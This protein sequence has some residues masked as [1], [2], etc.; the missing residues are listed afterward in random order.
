MDN[1]G[2][3]PSDESSFREAVRRQHTRVDPCFMT[4]KGCVYRDT[5]DRTLRDRARTD[6]CAGFMIMP[7]RDNLDVFYKNTLIPFFKGNYAADSRA[8]TISLERADEVRRPGIIICEGICK[9]VQES[10]FVVVDISVPNDNV[11][12]E[13]GLAYGIGQKILVVHHHAAEFGK[14]MA[15]RFKAAGYLSFAYHD[16]LPI[17]SVDFSASRH[18]WPSRT[19]TGAS[20]YSAAEPD[21]LFLFYEHLFGTDP[22]EATF[23]KEARD[24]PKGG[25]IALSFR[26]HVMSNVGLAVDRIYQAIPPADQA[27]AGGRESV[28]G[29]YRDI[30]AKLKEP[31]FLKPESQFLELKAQ[32]DSCYCMM[33]RTGREVHPLSYFWLGYGH[34]LGKNIIPITVAV[35]DEKKDNIDDLA[36]DIRAQ[37]HMTFVL[38]KPH[39]LETQIRTTLQEMIHADF[40]EW[41]RKRFWDQMLGKR[42]EVSV[43]T[44]A[45]HHERINREMIGDWDLRAA[46]ELMS[47]F[48]RH[49]YRAK[50]ETPIYSLEYAKQADTTI[51]TETYI[52]QLRT[53]ME[54]KNCIL[55]ASPDVNPL[56]EIVLGHIYG[57]QSKDLFR[58]PLNLVEHPHAMV[59]IKQVGRKEPRPDETQN[60]A[61]YLEE[62]PSREPRG[63]EDTHSSTRPRRGFRS[64]SIKGHT[65]LESFI[66]QQVTDGRESFEVFAHLA[67]VP[68]PW[69]PDRRHHIIILNGVSGPATFALTHVLTGGVNE[70]FVSYESE[71]GR[72]NPEAASESVL[73]EILEATRRHDFRG[74]ECIV[75]VTV[76]PA[77]DRELRKAAGSTFD[78]RRILRWEID[79]RSFGQRL[80]LLTR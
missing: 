72:F 54:G 51:T 55:I 52:T 57:V 56:T 21:K 34:A 39:L 31:K 26:T 24:D 36:F 50:I 9:R 33:V 80:H 19:G 76:G 30:I 58:G 37:R 29:S 49:Q 10:D 2:F 47:Y 22:Y 44:G 75:K 59:A 5:I 20:A 1:T 38:K 60:R 46:S 71:K 32:V 4:G 12:Y 14:A 79:T 48:S 68:N 69:D 25:D 73:K 35:E 42:G 8:E 66:S 6:T 67:I 11:F 61:F 17:R 43:F 18:I 7:F 64:A 53:M 77:E 65:I 41:S 13:L 23:A 70:E 40:A 63:E 45:L 16:L 28:I 62:E 74:L 15:D 78:W 27:D 3:S